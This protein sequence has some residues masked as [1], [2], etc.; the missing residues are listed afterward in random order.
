[1]IMEIRDVRERFLLYAKTSID[2]IRVVCAPADKISN[3][4]DATA[5]RVRLQ[6]GK[7]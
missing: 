5:L 3:V 7:T 2:F 4:S 1:M 6:K